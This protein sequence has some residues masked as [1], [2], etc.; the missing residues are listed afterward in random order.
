LK[1]LN[2]LWGSFDAHHRRPLRLDA[3]WVFP[4]PLPPSRHT[5]TCLDMVSEWKKDIYRKLLTSAD[6]PIPCALLGDNADLCPDVKRAKTDHYMEAI[7]AQHAFIATCSKASSG[8][9]E[10]TA[11]YQ[12]APLQRQRRARSLG[13]S[14]EMGGPRKIM[15]S[16]RTALR[17]GAAVR[18]V[19]RV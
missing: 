8:T 10:L 14:H 1:Y 6:R 2:S 4:S 15:S 17:A 12:S 19:W 5:R 9:D 7:V 11:R 16:T 3:R 13:H 18:S